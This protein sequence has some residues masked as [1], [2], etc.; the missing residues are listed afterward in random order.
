MTLSVFLELV[1]IKAKTASIFPFLLGT[2]FAWYHYRSIHPVFLILFFIAM[3]VFNM[4]VDAHDNY[5]DYTRATH[6]QDFRRKTNIIGV[7]HLNPKKIAWMTILMMVSS[8]LIGLIIVANVGWPLLV[9]GAWCFLVGW[10]YAAGPRP[11]SGTPFG[12]FFSG[13]TMGFM[14]TL[15]AVYINVYDQIT[16]NWAFVWPVLLA[17]GLAMTMIASLLLANNFCDAQEDIQ[18]GRKTIVYYIGVPNS[19][20]FYV[21]LEI[22]GYASLVLAVILNVL[23][24]LSLLTL[25]TIPIIVK[26]TQK[27]LAKQVKKETFIFAV[28]NLFVST[29]ALVVSFG[30]GLLLP[31]GR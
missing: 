27:L 17:S 29:L 31:L 15:I 16:F 14:I 6:A 28:K 21:G 3:F 24:L 30:L 1:E 18:L 11:I 12:E 8:G 13:F 25:L 19:L 20:K 10:F 4:A 22:L 5:Q 7:N 26:N 2:F 23:P 9:M